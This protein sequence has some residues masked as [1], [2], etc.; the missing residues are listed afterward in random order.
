MVVVG[1][2][3]I[4]FFGYGSAYIVYRW[5]NQEN[6]ED[7]QEEKESARGT[8]AASVSTQKRSLSQEKQ[9]K[10]QEKTASV[11]KTD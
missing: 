7:Q 2:S 4:A 10:S 3:L 1:C 8:P 5:E 6:Q 9:G 11:E